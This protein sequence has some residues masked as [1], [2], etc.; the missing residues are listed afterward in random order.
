MGIAQI[1]FSGGPSLKFRLDP[2]S[3]DW[4]FKILTSVT[5]TMGGRVIQVL[6]ATLSDITIKGSVGEQ[7][8]KTH[9][10]SWQLAEAF[11]A[12]IADLMDFQ[13]KGAS[14]L[15]DMVPPA[16]FT[17]GPLDISLAVYIKNLADADGESGISHRQGKFSYGYSLTLFIEPEG[18]KILKIAGTNSDG[19]VDTKRKQAI[20]DA[21]NRIAN[22]IGWHYSDP[23]NGPSLNSG[24]GGSTTGADLVTDSTSANKRG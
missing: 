4:N 23:F 3:I 6:G 24:I 7:R 19:Y 13:S 20:E 16:R 18:S 15:S 10:T 12:K 11:Y 22:G 9:Y 17:Y 1:A 5:E 21:M 14:G 2:E 8:G